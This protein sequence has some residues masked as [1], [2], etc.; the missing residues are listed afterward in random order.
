MP[1]TA[2]FAANCPLLV[3]SDVL[4]LSPTLQLEGNALHDQTL[5]AHHQLHAKAIR[6]LKILS[7]SESTYAA[8]LAREKRANEVLGFLN[9]IGAIERKRTYNGHIQ[10]LRARLYALLTGSWPAA[11]AHRQTYSYPA[12]CMAIIKASAPVLL[13]S[14]AVGVLAASADYIGSDRIISLFVSTSVVFVS[15]LF[16]HEAVHTLFIRHAGYQ[17]NIIRRGMRLGLLHRKLTPAYEIYSALS[18]PLAGAALCFVAAWL[19]WAYGHRLSGITLLA[20]AL[21]HM[22]SLLPWYGDGASLRTALGSHRYVGH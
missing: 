6:L 8:L 11:L 15:S 4:S 7:E 12:L 16:V 21:C 22:L 20:S 9:I 17:I 5:G 2:T 1:V 18:G 19:A 13:A 14:L 3:E 10:A